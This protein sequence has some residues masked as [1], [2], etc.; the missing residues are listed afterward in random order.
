MPEFENVE[1]WEQY[2]QEK[3]PE[4]LLLTLAL[5]EPENA[6]IDKSPQRLVVRIGVESCDEQSPRLFA[7]DY[8]TGHPIF[9]NVV[10]II[11]SED[12]RLTIDT[13][14][15]EGT[16]SPRYVILSK[17]ISENDKRLVKAR[18]EGGIFS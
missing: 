5:G 17:H 18:K 12:G 16:P 15:P 9:F 4:G 2:F 8:E 13:G 11:D 3:F 14:A 6:G 1:G 10:E 7:S